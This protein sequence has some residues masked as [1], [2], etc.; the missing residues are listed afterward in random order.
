MT[1]SI[2]RDGLGMREVLRGTSTGAFSTLGLF[3]LCWATV[4]LGMPLSATHA[5]VALFTMQPAGSADALWMGG[6]W[7]FLAGGV[8]GA[9]ITHCY[10]LGGRVF[11]R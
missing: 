9:L 7:A 10:H 2:A 4:P 8:G 11:I 6:L 1:D 5:F 3:L